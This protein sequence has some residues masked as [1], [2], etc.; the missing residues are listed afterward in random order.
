MYIIYCCY[1]YVYVN[2][3]TI[4]NVICGDFNSILIVSRVHRLSPLLLCP[5]SIREA[6][7][8]WYFAR[9]C[10]YICFFVFFF[11]IEIIRYA[12][13]IWVSVVAG[14]KTNGEQLGGHLCRD[15]RNLAFRILSAT[16]HCHWMPFSFWSFILCKFVCVEFPNNL[17]CGV[18]ICHCLYGFA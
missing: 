15:C 9:D 13:S 8:F 17:T 18:T 1:V 7:Y 6:F 11:I 14:W 16:C 4:V 3:C 5:R 12:F 10:W 2:V